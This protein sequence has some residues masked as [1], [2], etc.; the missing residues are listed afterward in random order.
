MGERRLW[1]A[2]VAV[3]LMLPLAGSVA[4]P[5]HPSA[6]RP[7]GTAATAP[8]DAAIDRPTLD[9]AEQLLIRECMARHGFPLWLGEPPPEDEQR[10]FPYVLDD[11]DWARR[12]GFGSDI[13]AAAQD[14][15]RDD[16]NQR[17]FDGLPPARRAAALVAL[18][19]ARPEGLEA[20]LPSGG[21]VRRSADGCRSEAERRLYG[22]LQA[23][24]RARR[25]VANLS[26]VRSGMVLADPAY[27]AAL[28][29]WARCMRGH[30]YA[31]DSPAHLRRTVVDRARDAEVAAA[32]AEATCAAAGLAATA[33]DLDARYDAELAQ[34][35]RSDIETKRRLELAADPRARAIVAAAE[36]TR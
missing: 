5:A 10:M 4:R 8:G 29:A 7:R 12:H 2:V 18:N 28:P 16:P 17:Y 35:Y 9:L 15:R 31:V 13:A 11:V 26:V 14:R 36:P 32:V 21:V 20:R 25:V 27:A 19:G 23:W 22:D 30:G 34:R 3:L 33:R 1:R 24:Y 6:E